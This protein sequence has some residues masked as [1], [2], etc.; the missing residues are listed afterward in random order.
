MISIIVPVYNI[1]NYL[2]R[3]MDSLFAQTCPAFEVI[4]VDDGSTDSSGVLCDRYAAQDPR[5][6]I[7]HKKNGGLSSAR[8]AG[9]D[10][11]RGQYIMFLDGD[12]YLAPC[13]LRLLSE[14]VAEV[15]DFDFIQFHYAETDGSW[16]A[17]P[18][19]TVSIQICTELR[20]MFCYIYQH[21]GVAASA[22]TKLYQAALIKKL[23]FREGIAHEDEEL[24]TRML[25]QCRRVVYTD[26]VIYGYIM[27]NG[28]IIHGS[29]NPHKLD[30]L[31]IMDERSAVLQKLGYD[32]LATET[33]SRQFRTTANLYC[34]A[35]RA[36]DS[37]SAKWLG[38]KLKA[39]SKEKNL[40]LTGQY[41]LLYYLT[42]ITG[43]APETYYCIR[44]IYGKS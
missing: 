36:G 30:V 34:Q 8:N 21:G 15:G 12:D 31:G 27:R 18:T 39:L 38:S 13:A 3:C 14:V 7:L 40:L 20:E 35:R 32:D 25:P 1:E 28:S 19:Q 41:R 10:A 23:R 17:A 43:F 26:L 4:L 44:R 24:A 5:I 16:Q 29:F 37:N 11:A 6:Q 42:R 2:P 9:L 22:C 33:R